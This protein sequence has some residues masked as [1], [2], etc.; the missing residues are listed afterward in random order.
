[1]SDWSQLRQS[2]IDAGEEVLMLLDRD[3]EP[4]ADLRGAIEWQGPR[5]ANETT[6]ATFALRPEHPATTRLLALDIEDDTAGAA[7]SLLHEA[8]YILIED[9]WE[10]DVYRVA[11][12]VDP[13]GDGDGLITVEAKSLFRFVEKI[14]LWA[15]PGN[16]LIAQLKYRD[17]R[18]GQSLRVLKEYL[19]V[20]L[21]NEY[22][23]GGM[24]GWDLWD[25]QSWAGVNPNLWAAMVN[26]INADVVTQFT[27]LDA[28]FDMAGDMFKET[29]NAAGLMLTVDMW[30]VGDDQ[31]FPDYT[32]LSKPTIIIDVVPRQFDTA[33]TGTAADMLRGLVRTFSV[34]ANAPR[35]GLGDTPATAA[36]RLPWVVWRPEDM[37]GV[38]GHIAV[39]KSEDSH[40]IV[41][42]KSPEAL[43]RL[44]AG[45]AKAIFGGLGAALAGAIPVFG[46]LINAAAIF[47]GEVVGESMKDKLFAWQSFSDAARRV[48]HGRFTYRTQVGAGDGWTLS[49][50]QQ[51]F[52]MLEAGSGRVQIQFD[53][54]DQSVYEQGRDYSCGDQGGVLHRDRVWSTFVSGTVRGRAVDG[55]RIREVTLG[56]PRALEDP[57][58][59]L[60]RSA[61]SINNA[62]SRFKTFV[63]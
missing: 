50:M 31:P 18:A 42:G 21:L 12:I 2:I 25:P 54:D 55:S 7:F 10:R 4:V 9:R 33:V 26:P 37:A 3:G 15:S 8:F 27:V 30:L 57:V 6:V 20:A 19:Q 52:Q 28:R 1:M 5:E 46:G 38:T 45:G 63:A 35:V 49:A 48:L 11:R 41:G 16:P 61:K 60:A 56:D 24:S 44:I 29:L 62:V 47:L 51:G 17:M 53:V 22:Q 32:V 43:N 39:V 13:I 58:K 14:A 34:E 23:P 59:A 40:V 36:G